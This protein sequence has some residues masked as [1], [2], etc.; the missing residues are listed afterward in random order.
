MTDLN[1]DCKVALRVAHLSM[2]QGTITR[3]SGFSA[4][5]KTFTITILAGLA[6]ITLQADAAQLGVIAM[7]A[8]IVLATIDTYYMTMEL[9]F[10]ALYDEVVT[11]NLND[12]A[13][14]AIAPIKQPGDVRRAINS[15]PSKLFYLPVLFACLLFIGYGLTHDYS[16]KRLSHSD[17]PRFDQSPDAKSAVKT[18]H[19]ERLI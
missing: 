4:S 10:R 1:T 8:S 5:A 18:K 2:I 12:A 7:I 11:R 3:M 13:D 19:P 6:A 14:L 9:R 16:T 15:K 17:T